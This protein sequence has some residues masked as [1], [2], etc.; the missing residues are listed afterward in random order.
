LP[1]I[2]SDNVYGY[3]TTALNEIPKQW[4]E[5]SV[6]NPKWLK[7]LYQPPYDITDLDPEILNIIHEKIRKPLIEN[8]NRYAYLKNI[9]RKWEVFRCTVCCHENGALGSTKDIEIF[10]NPGE[11]S[12]YTYNALFGATGLFADMDQSYKIAAAGSFTDLLKS[13]RSSRFRK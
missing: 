3:F 5:Y 1:G 8:R 4:E 13:F 10:T 6:S 11:I 9:K 2:Y 12:G 7:T